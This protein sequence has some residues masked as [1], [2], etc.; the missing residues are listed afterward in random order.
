MSITN[1]KLKDFLVFKNEFSA[2]FCPGVNIL[3][4][5]NG[6]GK[7]TLMKALYAACNWRNQT[8]DEERLSHIFS[9]FS[10]AYDE[11][12]KYAD[13]N[14]YSFPPFYLKVSTEDSKFII[15][16][17]NDEEDYHYREGDLLTLK[18]VFV[19]SFE[20]YSRSEGLLSLNERYTLGFDKTDMDL[21]LAI[22]MPTLRNPSNKVRTLLEK[23]AQI[24]EYD[25]KDGK[26]GLVLSK[27]GEKDI[28]LAFEASGYRK[29]YVLWMLLAN[30]LLDDGS[31]LFWDEPENSLNSELVPTIVEI[32]LEI[33]NN[34]VQIFI[35]SHD[36]NFVR[37]FDIRKSKNIPV[38]FH[39][40]SKDSTGQ[41]NCN[42]SPKYMKLPNNHLEKAAENL[43]EAVITDAMEGNGDVKQK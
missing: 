23:I 32:L 31:V 1:V 12:N 10:F 38:L 41:I 15:N 3:L 43:Y 9:Y 34:G 22:G 27:K 19:P 8:Y 42:S 29:L 30:G 35:A 21:L 17:W 36:Y 4:G 26:D 11:K 13:S 28:D 24:I 25:I 40:L 20:L 18:T 7:T 37:Y 6:T 14:G 5:W 39:Y 2:D 16:A 33:A